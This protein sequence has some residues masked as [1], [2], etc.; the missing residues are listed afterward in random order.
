V[1]SDFSGKRLAFRV[2]LLRHHAAVVGVA[3]PWEKRVSNAQ[4]Q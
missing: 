1:G 2:D 3:L 4:R